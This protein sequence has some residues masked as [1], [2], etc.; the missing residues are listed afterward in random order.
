[1]TRSAFQNAM[2]EILDVPRGSL[3]ESDSRDSL[4]NWSSL[5][6]VQILTTINTELGLEPDAELLGAETVGDLFRTLEHRG[7][8]S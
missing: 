6:D 7:A 4:E 5:A 1:M 3:K 8:F 2:E